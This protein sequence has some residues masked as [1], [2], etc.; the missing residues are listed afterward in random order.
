MA[1]NKELI[2]M[3][4]EEGFPLIE[5]VVT[6]SWDVN[7]NLAQAYAVTKVV[8]AS[9]SKRIDWLA[10]LLNQQNVPTA[11]TVFGLSHAS[12]PTYTVADKMINKLPHL[13]SKNEKYV[14]LWLDSLSLEYSRR[15]ASGHEKCLQR[16]MV[17][18]YPE[19]LK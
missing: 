5:R 19:E 2:E 12:S 6:E 9:E 14:V 1:K 15:G 11:E 3:M 18:H 4:K 17:L 7:R 10:R 8:R 16:G 13:F